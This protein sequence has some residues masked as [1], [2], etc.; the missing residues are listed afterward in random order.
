MARTTDEVLAQLRKL[1]PAH[2][3]SAEALLAGFAAALGLAEVALD[4]LRDLATV[5]DGTGM[6]LTLQAHGYG[7]RRATGETDESL[8]IRLRAVEDQVTRP[9]IK[10][11]V[12]RLIAPDECQIIEWFDQ[13]YLD[14]E[15]E[16][17]AWLDCSGCWVSGGPQ[18]FLVVVPMQSTGFA[19]GDGYLDSTL[20]LDVESYLAEGPEDPAYAAIIN[21]VERIR[22]AGVFWRLV[23][24]E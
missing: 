23:L 13:P 19:S 3:A 11:A 20:Y 10:A 15:G 1:L 18:S 22:A 9:A 7:L 6:W 2:Y 21:E 17:G 8:R 12:D 16:T 5:E 14:D 4:T 24:E